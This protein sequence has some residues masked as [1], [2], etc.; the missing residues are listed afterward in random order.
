MRAG[1]FS[2]L[3]LSVAPARGQL[4][5]VEAAIQQVSTDSLTQTVRAFTGEIPVVLDGAVQFIDSRAHTEPGNERA[6]QYLKS[7]VLAYGL[8]IDTICVGARKSLVASLPG[9]STKA[10]MLGAHYDNV[11]VPGA[12]SA[13]AD[14]NASGC[15]AVIEAARILASSPGPFP[16]PI[17][18]A[19]WDEEE[20]GF[21]GAEDYQGYMDP[22][23]LAGYIN[24][25]MIGY[26]GNGDSVVEVYARP[27]AA[28]EA[29]ANLAVGMAGVYG[30]GV[31]PQRISPAPLNTDYVPFW[32]RDHTAIGI[33]EDLDG[34][35]NSMY[36]Q[37][38][39]S[40]YLFNLPYF[41]KAAQLA[42]ATLLHS[43]LGGPADIRNDAATTLFKASILN[44]GNGATLV[45]DASE[46]GALDFAVY[47]VSGSL[48]CTARHAV[49]GG[50]SFSAALLPV[51]P[52]AGV[53]LVRVSFHTRGGRAGSQMLR[54]I[55]R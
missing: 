21:L 50:Q 10:W 3:F 19:F 44:A 39:D 31:L 16:H 14:D 30:I 9:T 51:A 53:Y 29:L 18:F 33:A 7:R 13:G 26:D 42:L 24:L 20:I 47:T 49:S 34:D 37:P 35:R 28:S 41:R 43:A 12:P 4:P 2:L 23:G 54:W 17:R 5:A 32:N 15:A 55:A 27:V 1:L 40:L 8:T 6:F 36:H 45:F 22:D 25:D 48:I 46:N 38:G 11:G 52:P